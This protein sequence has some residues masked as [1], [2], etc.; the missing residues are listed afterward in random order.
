MAYPSRAC[1]RARVRVVPILLLPLLAVAACG[2]KKTAVNLDELVNRLATALCKY[3]VA[4][5]ATPDMASCVASVFQDPDETA[6]LE[7]NIASGKTKYDPVKA[8]T[9]VEWFERYYGSA[10]CTQSGR[11]ALGT[12]SADACAGAFVGTVAPGGACITSTECADSGVCQPT[13]PTCAQQCC[14]GTCVARAAPIP[15]GGDCSTLQ[16]NQSCATGSICLPVAGGSLTCLVPSTVEG[17]ACAMFFDCASPLFCATDAGT[18]TKSCRRAAASGA[19]CD[20]SASVYNA[21]DD[22]RDICSPTTN[23]CV[24]RTAVGGTCDP[25]RSACVGYA[26]CVGTT[27][28]AYPKP[29]EACTPG[30]SPDCLGSFECAAQ[31]NTCVAPSSDGSCL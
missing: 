23:T 5:E 27:C 18:G 15:V 12:D 26:V 14:P 20:G 24:R 13:E 2:D 28:V 21:C 31:T 30:G 25:A 10:V 22:S 17:S 11:A 4:C 1:A 7:A 8:N 29:G 9:C 19:A 6:V 16:P 3:E